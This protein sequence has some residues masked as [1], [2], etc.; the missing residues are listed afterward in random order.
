[1]FPL[2]WTESLAMPEAVPASGRVRNFKVCGHVNMV[3]RSRSAGTLFPR[4]RESRWRH[5][6]SRD[7]QVDPGL[8]LRRTNAA[9]LNYTSAI[10]LYIIRRSQHIW[11]TNIWASEIYIICLSSLTG[12]DRGYTPYDRWLRPVCWRNRLCGITKIDVLCMNGRV[13]KTTG[14]QDKRSGNRSEHRSNMDDVMM[15]RSNRNSNCRS[16]LLP[17]AYSTAKESGLTNHRQIQVWK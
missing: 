17:S 2:P 7:C 12:F 5:T 4:Q 8:T 3:S 6:K 1:M 13:S 11:L 14:L 9:L 16:I 10:H 15:I